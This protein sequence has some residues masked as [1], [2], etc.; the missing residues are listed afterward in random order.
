MRL[1]KGGRSFAYAGRVV[2]IT[3]GSRGLGLLMARELRK[4]GARLALLGVA[5]GLAG[6][7]LVTRVVEKLLYGVEATDAV[8]F[9]TVPV[10]LAA[11]A[12]L[13]SVVPARRATRVDPV[14]AMKAE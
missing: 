11:V 1:R 6:A 4:K 12:I 2:V 3:G 8:T 10:L 14:V 7:F 13:A 9:V 5:I